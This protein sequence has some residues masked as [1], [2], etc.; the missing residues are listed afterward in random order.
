MRYIFTSDA[1]EFYKYFLFKFFFLH[2]NIEM[3]YIF[4]IVI[5]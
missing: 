2:I 4:F 1:L 5:R 3:I